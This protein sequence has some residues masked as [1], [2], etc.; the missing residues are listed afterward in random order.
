[1]GRIN[2]IRRTPIVAWLQYPLIIFT[3][4]VFERISNSFDMMYGQFDSLINWYGYLGLVYCQYLALSYMTEIYSSHTKTKGTFI[5]RV[6]MIIVNT[7]SPIGAMALAYI[8]IIEYNKN[9]DGGCVFVFY[10]ALAVF[11]SFISFIICMVE[12]IGPDETKYL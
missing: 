5:L 4:S 6:K 9:V 11:M 10:I 7:L 8:V 2:R 12:K 1:M 3:L